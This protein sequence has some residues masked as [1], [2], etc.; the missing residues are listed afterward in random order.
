ML[1]RDLC[2]S[3]QGLLAQEYK[4]RRD[5]SSSKEGLLLSS[6]LLEKPGQVQD[7]GKTYCKPVSN[8][9]K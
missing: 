8:W 7:F 3:K 6:D 5:L 1:E 2:S 9:S 4:P